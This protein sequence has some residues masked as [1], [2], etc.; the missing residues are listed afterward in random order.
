MI[1]RSPVAVR[2][3]RLVR[4]SRVVFLLAL[5]HD[6]E[7]TMRY[8]EPSIERQ[9]LP[10]GLVVIAQPMPHVHSVSVGVWVRAGSRRESARRNG[11]AH[12]IEHMVFKGTERRTAEDIARA[13]DSVGGLLDA[14]TSKEAVCF[15]AKV[16]AEHLP[17]AFDVLSDLVLRPLFAAGDIAKEK[18]VILEEIKMEEDNPESLA[19]EMLTQN[20]WRGNPLGSPILGTRATVRRFTRDALLDCFRPWYAPNNTLITA[21]G[22]IEMPQLVGLARKAFG[23]RKPHRKPLPQ[24]PP[25][26]PHARLVARDKPALEQAHITIGVP[27]YPLADPRRYAASVLN[28]ILGGGMSSRL[29]QNIREQ[30]G[31]AYAVFSE[32]NPYSDAGMLSIYVSTSR[33]YAERVLRSVAEEFRRLKQEPVS[34]AEMRRAKDHLRGAL[35]LSLE[36]TGARMSNLAR[37]EMYFGRFIRV[38]E[39]LASL[40][41]VT[42]EHVQQIAR[43]FFRPDKIAVTVLGPLGNFRL[44]RD[45]L[46]C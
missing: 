43:E 2:D 45:L 1:A 4:L 23:R 46:A 28:D 42:C 24:S 39:L 25:P 17:L 9:V 10:N 30:Q 5:C 31:L 13:V 11:I 8:A 38:P 12:F 41:A 34:A 27:S 19:H 36:S 20:F 21:A 33:H 16:L 14:F 32:L 15:N 26:E 44:H 40:E 18:Q 29:F 6:A 3:R 7:G 35:L 22:R 37:Q